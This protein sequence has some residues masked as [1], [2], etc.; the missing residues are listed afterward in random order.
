M[1]RSS[2]T[3]VRFGWSAVHEWL[4]TRPK[5]F[6]SRGINALVKRWPKFIELEGDCVEQ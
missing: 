4:H 5:E 2:E 1:E 6:F 3:T